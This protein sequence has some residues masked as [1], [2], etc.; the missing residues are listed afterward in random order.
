M[1]SH[2]TLTDG[3]V[4]KSLIIFTLPMIVGDLLQQFYNITDTLIVGQALG[5]NAL[6]AVGAA[7]ALMIFLTSIFLGLSMGAGALFSIYYGKQDFESLKSAVVQAFVLI[8][9]ITLILNIT[10]Y[11]CIDPILMF[12]SIPDEIYSSMRLYLNII[13]AGI[14]ATS[15]YNYLACLLR[16]V[17]NSVAPLWFLGIGAILNVALDVLLVIVFN[18]GI[19]GAAVATIIAQYVCGI[20]ILVYFLREERALIPDKENIHIDPKLMKEISDLSFLTCVQQSCMNFGILLVQRLV[21]S[22]GTVTIAAFSAAV[23]IDT[24]AYLP[25]QDFGNAFSTY[26]AQNYGAGNIDRLKNGIRSALLITSVF[27]IVISILVVFN[28]EFLMKLFINARETD[29]IASGIRYLRIEGAFY[30]GIGCLFLLY[31]FYR[32]VK[33][34]GVS[35]VLTVISLGLRVVLAYTIAPIFGEAGIWVSIPIGWLMADA[36]G[37]IYYRRY[38]SDLLIF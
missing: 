7:Y 4:S 36:A 2:R 37:L 11:L 23:K 15:L 28:A 20:G 35:L 33:R 29:V 5:K 25:V 9:G 6:A 16:A 17:G 14:V 12:L 32:A 30:I 22:F 13:F 27:S 19:A 1:R 26:I 21:N 31:G 34:P 24:F 10:V 3:N 8:M 18:F 38:R